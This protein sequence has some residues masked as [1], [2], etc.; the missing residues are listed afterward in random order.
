[1]ARLRRS[2]GLRFGSVP[3]R[4]LAEVGVAV[5]LV[6]SSTTT[7]MAAASP[8][9]S[10]S[11]V[12]S[13]STSSRGVTKTRHHRGL[14]GGFAQLTGR[15][16]GFRRGRRVRGAD[17][18]HQAL[19]ETGQPGWG[20][21]RPED[22]S[23]HQR[24]RPDQRNADAVIVQDL[25]TGVTGGLRRAGRPRGLDRGQ[26]ALRNPG[27]PYPSHRRVVDG[28]Q[29]DQGGLALPLVDR[30]RPGDDPAG[31]GQLGTGRPSDRW[32]DQGGRHRRQPGL[33]SGR[34]QHL[35]PA[36]SPQPPASTRS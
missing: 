12:S 17:Q 16:G 32:Q 2:I 24:L 36:R 25:D 10:F 15:P 1:M 22:R 21:R 13:A 6:A 35:S 14:P 23:H 5:A 33:G 8:D 7:S 20:H 11:P 34:P 28:H 31:R 30:S 18:G 19:R 27:R 9:N 4:V 3:I 29:L 26:P